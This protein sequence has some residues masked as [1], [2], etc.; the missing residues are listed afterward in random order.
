MGIHDIEQVDAAVIQ[1]SG[2]WHTL[3]VQDGIALYTANARNTGKHTGTVAVSQ[4]SLNI[5]KRNI[6]YR[7]AVIFSNK[8]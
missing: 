4:S 6:L 8:L 2:H 1:P 5:G 3:P 7:A